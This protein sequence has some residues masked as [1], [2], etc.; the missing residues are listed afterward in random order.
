M[1]TVTYICPSAHKFSMNLRVEGE[2]YKI[3]FENKELHLDAVEDKAVIAVFDKL[4]EAKPNISQIVQKVDPVVAEKLAMDHRNAMARMRGTQ[5]GPIT[6]TSQ[7]ARARLAERDTELALQGATPEALE[8]M[9]QEIDKDI[10]LTK[11]SEGEIAPD[12][13]DGFEETVKPPLPMP[14]TTG[15][16]EAESTPKNVFANLAKAAK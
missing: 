12:T 5:T 9:H 1:S 16:E 11:N 15:P 7:L 13:R 3:Q 6:S 10:M 14:E 4:I 2:V 8:K